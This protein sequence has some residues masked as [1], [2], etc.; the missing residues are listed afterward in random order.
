[1][2]KVIWYLAIRA[3]APRKRSWDRFEFRL[4]NGDQA[5]ALDLAHSKIKELRLREIRG[6]SIAPYK[7]SESDFTDS[8]GQK[9]TMVMR[10]IF[11]CA[12]G[13]QLIEQVQK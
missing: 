12:E 8:N 13:I 4:E 2:D 10:S 3:K 6:A 1:M 11:P 9:Q 5:I 7:C